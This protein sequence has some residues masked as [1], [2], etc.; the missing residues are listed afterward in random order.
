M[1]SLLRKIEG[2]FEGTR[3]LLNP[4]SGESRQRPAI[5]TGHA[6][7]DAVLPGGILPGVLHEVFAGDMSAAA[8][9]F[10]AGLAQRVRGQKRLLWIRQD[11]AALEHGEICPTGLNEL[12]ID[13]SAVLILRTANAADALKAAADALSCIA[14]GAVIA[15]VP[16]NPKILDLVATRRLTLGARNKGVTAIL[17]RPSAHPEPSATETRWTIRTHVSA[18]HDEDWGRPCFDA[19]LVRNRHGETGRWAME[20]NCDDGVFAKPAGHPATDHGPV[21]ATL[22]D[23]SAQAEDRDWR[24][25]G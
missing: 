25:A 21:A 23:G 11:Y 18:E 8:S 12:G 24:R 5:A 22:A 4:I 6:D 14:L 9:G 17:L 20:W 13:P 7:A 19:A 16:G 10:A 2:V 3:A 15:E 1:D